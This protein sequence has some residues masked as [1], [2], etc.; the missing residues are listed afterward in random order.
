ML[1]YNI[2]EL[3]MEVTQ[4]ALMMR[5]DNEMPSF[6][7]LIPKPETLEFQPHHKRNG[8]VT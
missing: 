3:F 1:E 7:I 2:S 4:Y 5:N 8:I 6:S